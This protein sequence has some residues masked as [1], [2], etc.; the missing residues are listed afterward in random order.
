M[1]TPQTVVYL[2]CALLL[3]CGQA[4]AH[5]DEVLRSGPTDRLGEVHF[6]TS[7]NRPAQEQ[8]SQAVAMLHSFFY[9]EALKALIKVTELDPT[10]AMGYWGVAMSSWYPL[11]YPPTKESLAQG[12]S[13]LEK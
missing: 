9:T 3:T 1:K 2:I 12:A 6:P 13:A 7:C 8:F 5:E 10:C 11:W 4:N